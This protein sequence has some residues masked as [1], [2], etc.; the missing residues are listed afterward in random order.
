MFAIVKKRA[1]DILIT[2]GAGFIG[3]NLAAHLIATTDARVVILDNLS[4][5]AAASNLDWLRLQAGVR[6]LTFMREDVR[7][8]AA[9]IRAANEADQ[10]YHLAAHCEGGSESRDEFDVN[11][12]GTLNLLEAARYSPRR[13]SVVYVSTSR[14]YGELRGLRVQPHGSCYQ[15]VEAGFRGV[16]EH[17]P[18]NLPSPHDCSRETAERHVL[19]Y[20][21][22]YNLPA[23]ALRVDTV[24]GPRQFERRGR[25]WVSHFVYSILAGRA[26]TVHGSGLQVHDVLDVADL[27]EAM[28]A[29]EAY[30]GVTRGQVYNVGG[31]KGHAVSINKMIGLIETICHRQ[32]IVRREPARSGDRPFYYADTS[33]FEA[34]TG[35]RIRRS[36]EQT[37][38]SVAAFWHSHLEKISA[39]QPA[40]RRAPHSFIQAA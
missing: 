6:R 17:A 10:I 18:V 28:V 3:S 30:L 23:V 31:G 21:R 11:V 2:G 34:A 8:A 7:N 38:R 40:F 33:A 4:L 19:D 27:V 29:A 35:W 14:D 15:S 20:A 26:V 24:A 5:P 25:G 32:A 12:T 22:L 9:L 36:L 39:R 37:V 16:N 1:P 13:P